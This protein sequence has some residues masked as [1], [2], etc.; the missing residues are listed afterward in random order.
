MDMETVG[1]LVKDTLTSE[2]VESAV[3]LLLPKDS[4]GPRLGNFFS[5]RKPN[6]LMVGGMAIIGAAAGI[7]AAG[8][9]GSQRYEMNRPEDANT[10]LGGSRVIAAKKS[11]VEQVVNPSVAAAGRAPSTGNAPNLN[12]TGDIVF[13]MHNARR[14]G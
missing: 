8:G 6:G 11:E 13:G 14:G 1:S 4:T 9:L 5:G 7:S 12:A 3:N 2:G 10:I